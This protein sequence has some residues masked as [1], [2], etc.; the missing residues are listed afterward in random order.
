MKNL[1]RDNHYLPISYQFG[2]TNSAGKVWVKFAHKLEPVERNPRSVG[3]QR[4]LYIV[5]R[6]GIPHDDVEDFFS[7]L[8]EMPFA[9][10]ARRI[11]DEKNR[12]AT[13]T[14]D[15]SNALCTF[16]ALQVVRTI[17][18][19][20]CLDEQAGRDL[21]SNA[22]VGTLVRQALGII[23]AWNEGS[24]EL[25]FYTPLPHIGDRFI[26]GDSPVV[27]IQ[28]NDNPIW[29]PRSEPRLAITD[30]KQLL[31]SPNYYFWIPLSPY[32]CASLT[33]RGTQAT[34][35]PPRVADP[36]L[37]RF[38]NDRIREQSRIFTLAKDKPS[39]A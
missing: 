12:F 6:G 9:P 16:I 3:R 19:K 8:V 13:I 20:R 24:P 23:E 38:L 21:D 14:E 18:H 29:I 36:Q 30:V 33:G 17:A 11:R 1:K 22:F 27:T 37:V 25:Q 31:N 35:L 10:L 15:E 26:T 4:S 39:L 32:V 7:R 2:F 28:M 5:T 34:R